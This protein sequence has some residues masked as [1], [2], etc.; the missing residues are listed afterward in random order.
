MAPVEHKRS[1]SWTFG[2]LNGQFLEPLFSYVLGVVTDKA[3]RN[4]TL[5]FESPEFPRSRSLP[6]GVGGGQVTKSLSREL[7]FRRSQT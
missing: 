2:D 7:S 5:S 3:L 6:E 4:N 1:S